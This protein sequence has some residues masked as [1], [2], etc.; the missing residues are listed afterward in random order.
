MEIKKAVKD[1][2]KKTL[3]DAKLLMSWL[4][5]D[6]NGLK[7]INNLEKSFL[8]ELKLMFGECVGTVEIFAEFV[9]GSK[10]SGR[11]YLR[12]VVKTGID[13][14]GDIVNFYIDLKVLRSDKSERNLMGNYNQQIF[15]S[16]IFYIKENT[17]TKVDE[18][19][20][21]IIESIDRFTEM[22]GDNIRFKRLENV[23]EI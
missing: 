4:Y 12:D 13:L 15:K 6:K 17:K 9:D 1:T 8:E 19:D 10:G 22:S 3:E 7:T 11:A 5:N 20:G 16:D 14:P 2:R 18:S 23:I 21:I